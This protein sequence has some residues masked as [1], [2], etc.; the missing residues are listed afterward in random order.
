MP[1]QKFSASVNR[2]NPS[3][4]N[5]SD[6]KLKKKIT[7]NHELEDQIRIQSRKLISL[8]SDLKE[9]N[10]IPATFGLLH[11]NERVSKQLSLEKAD[12]NQ[13][14]LEYDSVKFKTIKSAVLQ[15]LAESSILI[16]SEIVSTNI[17][18]KTVHLLQINIKALK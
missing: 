7:F 9:E 16:E 14:Y 2:M 1:K 18:G 15:S 6:E 12:L 13:A 11:T 4:G 5:G 3:A 17:S 10:I 8:V